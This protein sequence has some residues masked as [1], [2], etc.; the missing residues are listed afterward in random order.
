GPSTDV[1]VSLS[2]PATA[3]AGATFSFVAVIDNNGPGDAGGTNVVITLPPGSGNVA[4]TCAANN[5]RATCPAALSIAGNVVTGVIP[6]LDFDVASSTSGSISLTVTGWFPSP[7]SSSVN[8]SVVATTPTGV[9]DSNPSSN[10]SNVSTV[11]DSRVD[12]AVTKTVS[13]ATIVDGQPV[14]YTIVVTNSGPASADG[15]VLADQLQ[16]AGTADLIYETYTSSFVDCTVSGGA[17]CPTVTAGRTG[18]INNASPFGA[19]FG[20]FPPG[21]VVTLRYAVTFNERTQPLCGSTA[22]GRIINQAFTYNRVDTNGAN[23]TSRVDLVTRPATDC[24]HLDLQTTKTADRPSVDIA[25]GEPIDFT[26]TYR[27]AGAGSSAGANIADHMLSPF[28]DG[29]TITNLACTSTAGVS[30][31]SLAPSA[32]GSTVY[33]STVGAW[34]PGAT[35]TITYTAVLT[36][37]EAWRRPV[38]AND[39][40]RMADNQSV[41]LVGPN[42][43]DDD[44]ANNI[45]AVR[46][47]VTG[48]AP[49]CVTGDIS[50]DKR[51]TGN[52][53]DTDPRQSV[54]FELVIANQGAT[55]ALDVHLLDQLFGFSLWSGT[56]SRITF[57]PCTSTQ[58]ATCPTDLVDRDVQPDEA[59]LIDTTIAALPAGST[60]TIPYE[61]TFDV[62]DSSLC[63]TP[64]F[65]LYNDVSVRP[66]P[67]FTDTNPD[68]DRSVVNEDRVAPTGC[69]DVAIIKSVDPTTAILGEPVTYTL[70]VSNAGTGTADA[71]AV[72]DA[73]PSFFQ[74]TSSSCTAIVGAASCGPID[75]VSGVLTTTIDVLAP[76]DAVDV[77]LVGIAV[78]SPGTFPNVATALVTPAP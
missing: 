33:E 60:L 54:P 13:P 71:V 46:F 45:A 8:A 43:I 2:G 64:N 72:R 35:M 61:V 49:E 20:R 50:V 14:V 38:C 75:V 10:S 4:A 76:G 32:N 40:N 66:G 31:P 58:Q 16:T 39:A 1:Q 62:P 17:A 48:A 21:A 22:P 36:P 18:S 27:N 15:A 3:N 29:A 25:A 24:V 52:A 19:T 55:D 11:L 73:L 7:G 23:N 12:L 42:E 68:N 51:F 57:G 63:S 78:G 59:Y 69:T 77:T 6:T 47:E 26:V 30:C 34:A 65:G 44:F 9:V 37:I 67:A 56:T 28:A 74:L 70:R 53:A 41:V 5:L